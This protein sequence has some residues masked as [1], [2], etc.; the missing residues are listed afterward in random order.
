MVDV[1]PGCGD[2]CDAAWELQEQ[3]QAGADGVPCVCYLGVY[4][5][6]DLSA[7]SGMRSHVHGMLLARWWENQPDAGPVEPSDRTVVEAPTLRL[8]A[9]DKSTKE[10]QIP[11]VLRKHFEDSPDFRVTWQNLLHDI[12]EKMGA[13]RFGRDTRVRVD[14]APPEPKSPSAVTM[15]GPEFLP[16]ELPDNLDQIL[17]VE[18]YPSDELD[19]SSVHFAAASIAF[20]VDLYEAKAKIV[21]V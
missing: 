1:L 3:W 16:G 11:E 21:C 12:S 13:L 19:M 7:F 9:L 6:D 5:K 17:E 20:I 15:R 4:R 14:D 18:T 10:P 2:W 8:L